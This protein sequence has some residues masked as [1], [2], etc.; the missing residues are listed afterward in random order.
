MGHFILQTILLVLILLSNV[1]VVVVTA[2]DQDLHTATNIG[3]TSL[4]VADLLLGVSWFYIQ[5][6]VFQHEPMITN[7]NP[8]YRYLQDLAYVFEMSVILH[9]LL[10]TVER[11]VAV[12]WPLWH[13]RMTRSGSPPVRISLASCLTVWLLAAFLAHT[14]RFTGEWL[15]CEMMVGLTLLRSILP[16]L[17]TAVLN[18]VLLVKI[19]QSDLARSKLLQQNDERSSTVMVN[20]RAVT[21]IGRRR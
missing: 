18:L 11:F 20:R 8:A 3:I 6:L 14:R 2:V 10:V 15:K 12:V 5:V 4:A 9:I 7:I 16:L 19:R 13:Y 1:M 21:T 17:L